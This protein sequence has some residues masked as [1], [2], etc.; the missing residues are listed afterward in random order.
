MKNSLFIL[1]IATMLFSCDDKKSVTDTAAN[2]VVNPTEVELIL[3]DYNPD[4]HKN[5]INILIVDDIKSI[6][7]QLKISDDGI[8]N[9]FPAIQNK[10]ELLISYDDREFSQIISPGEKLIISVRIE[11]F[12]NWSKFENFKVEGIHKE[13]N[14]ALLKHTFF[15]NNLLKKSTS[16]FSVDSLNDINLYKNKRIQEMHDQLSKFDSLV[17]QNNN[18]DA[19]FTN[20]GKLQI[21]YSAGS[22]LSVYPFMGKRSLDLDAESDYF[23]FVNEI[24]F[25]VATEVTYKAYLNYLATLTSLYNIVGNLSNSYS[26]KREQLKKDWPTPYFLKVQLIKQLPKGKDRDIIMANFYKNEI[27]LSNYTGNKIP[28][29]YLDTLK[30]YTNP[31]YV[32]AILNKQLTAQ[33]SIKTLIQNYDVSEKEKNEL[34][35]IYENTKGK[36]VFHDFWATW[37]GPCMR[38]LEHYNTLIESTDTDIVYIFYGVHMQT[39]DWEK[40]IKERNLKG[41]HYLLSKNQLAFFEKYFGVRSYPH[42]QIINSKGYIVNE[43]IPNLNSYSLDKIIEL[44]EKNK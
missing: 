38:E 33:K 7:K 20:W 37:C 13:T 14:H 15:I 19:T 22:D 43:Q 26:Q 39:N 1:F 32:D 12:L 42:H 27:R 36:V 24:G 44:I 35:K 41:N 21:K 28:N 40:T 2:K 34:L 25:N 4:V 5:F 29:N 11:E 30:L 31:L 18:T 8:V 17:S 9:Y 16:A 10:K 23:T 6:T 3:K